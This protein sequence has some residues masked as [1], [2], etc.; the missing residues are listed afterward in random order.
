MILSEDQLFNHLE[1]QTQKTQSPIVVFQT[2]KLE[3]G[4]GLT[5]LQTKF[6]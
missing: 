2:V 3:R 6:L 1:V 4:R 5:K